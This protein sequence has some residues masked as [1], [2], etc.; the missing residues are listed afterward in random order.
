MVQKQP[1]P[2]EAEQAFNKDEKVGVGAWL[3][4]FSAAN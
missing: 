2:H 1:V 3:V 4:A